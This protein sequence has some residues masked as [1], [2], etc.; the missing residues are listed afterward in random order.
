MNC[1]QP[2]IFTKGHDFFCPELKNLRIHSNDY[3]SKESRDSLSF[4]EGWGEVSR[5][6]FLSRIIEFE[7]SF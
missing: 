6:S 7:N 3:L 4:G 2:R 1:I 5:R